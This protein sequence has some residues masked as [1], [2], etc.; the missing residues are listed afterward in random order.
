MSNWYSS[1]DPNQ[2]KLQTGEAAWIVNE[3]QLK[4]NLR[5]LAQFTGSSERIFY[6]VKANPAI[7]V[8]QVLRQM[9][10]TNSKWLVLK[11]NTWI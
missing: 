6:P 10:L 8:L 9:V 1:L 2:I 5:R 4:S 3:D 7:P 11:F